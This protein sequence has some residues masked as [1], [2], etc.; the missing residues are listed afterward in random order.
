MAK[1]NFEDVFGDFLLGLD[2]ANEGLKSMQKIVNEMRKGKKLSLDISENEQTIKD[3]NQAIELNVEL[4][5]EKLEIEK[6]LQAELEKKSKAEK[7]IFQIEKELNDINKQLNQNQKDTLKTQQLYAQSVDL[8]KKKLKELE[9][10]GQK[11]NAEYIETKNA[12]KQV[13]TESKAFDKE[14]VKQQKLLKSAPDSLNKMQSELGEL[15]TAYRNGSKELRAQLLPQ[16]QKL[17]TEV[18]KLNA[19]IGNHQLNVGNYGS[20]FDKLDGILGNGRKIVYLRELT[21]CQPD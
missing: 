9:K 10:A 18:K 3:L 19:D 5:K 21:W 16:I 12:L 20:A 2:K 4:E 15:K 17:D 14:L 11:N 7:D 13:T 6:K 1:F 8:L